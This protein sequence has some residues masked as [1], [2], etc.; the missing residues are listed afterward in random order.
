MPRF[1]LA[2]LLTA[3]AAGCSGITVSQDYAPATSFD[4]LDTFAWAS[5]KQ[6][7]TGDPRIDNPL[8]DTRTR[9]AVVRQ[10]MAKGFMAATDGQPTFAIRYQYVLRR[11]LESGG[12]GS[13]IGFGVGTYGRG[14]GIAVGTGNSVREYEEVSLVIDLLDPAT[15]ELLWRGSGSQRYR[16]YKDPEKDNRDINLLVE[17][18]LN[19]FP[20]GQ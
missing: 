14:G 8:R 11:K 4:A 12:G 7:T 9:D 1:F 18:I 2:I 6:P 20:P 17:K 19:Q 15:D 10:L 5:P 3:M 13:R 16:E